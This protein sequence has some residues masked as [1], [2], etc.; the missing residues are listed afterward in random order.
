MKQSKPTK[1]AK[2]IVVKCIEYKAYTVQ[3]SCPTCKTIFAGGL[4]NKIHQF[5][6]SCGQKLEITSRK[7]VSEQ[8]KDKL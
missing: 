6:C 8:E 4:S 7:I 5:F 2:K 1:K 3:Y